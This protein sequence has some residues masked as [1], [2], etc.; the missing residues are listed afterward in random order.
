[1]FKDVSPATPW[2]PKV[3]DVVT[4]SPMGKQHARDSTE[5]VLAVP[6]EPGD[7]GVLIT[8][9]GTVDSD[10]LSP[11]PT[12]FRS[13]AW[14]VATGERCMARIKYIPPLNGKG[15]GWCF[16]LYDPMGGI[17][18]ISLGRADYLDAHEKAEAAMGV[19]AK[20]GG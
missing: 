8:R 13:G 10:D 6:T 19:G 20:G 16:E 11:A 17:A 18:L 7:S 14:V 2:T 12:E 9:V 3:G 5:A 15:G 1:M 4:Y